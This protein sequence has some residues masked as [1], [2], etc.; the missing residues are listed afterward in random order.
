L[1]SLVD[2]GASAGQVAAGAAL[3]R[4]LWRALAAAL[5]GVAG[6]YVWVAVSAV[7]FPY[8]LDYAEGLV[9]Q[10]ALWLGSAKLYGDITKFPFLV[11][12]Y[13]PLFLAVLKGF[14]L[15]GLNV[16]A[17]GRAFSVACTL[18]ACIFS[19]GLT[20]RMTRAPFGHGPG[21]W[22]A[23]VAGLTPL[24]LLPLLSWSVLMRVD[25]LALCLTYAGLYCASV[26]FRRG[27]ALWAALPCF[28]AAAF[29]KQIY[30]A[31]AAAM[32]CICVIRAPRRT[33]AV[34]AVWGAAALACLFALEW[35]SEGR[36]LKH[37]LVY[38]AGAIDFA[39]AARQT[40]VWL[41]AYP[42]DVGL[43]MT[44]VIVAWRRGGTGAGWLKRV[45][46]DEA[47]AYLCFLTVY[48]ALTTL[49]LVAA[50]K[51][52][53]SRN[54]FIEWM[55][56]WCLWLG[57]LAAYVLSRPR[58]AGMLG[59]LMPVLLTLQLA[60]VLAGIR[61][62]QAQE[63]S[64]QRRADWGA[65]LARTQTI[66]GPLLSDD[67]VT[68]ILAGREVTLEPCVLMVLS[69]LGFYDEAKLIERLRGHYFAAVI[70]A[71]DPGDPTFD[72]RYL[73]RSRD[74]LLA[75]Y[76]HVEKYGDYRLRLP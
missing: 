15:A 17:T 43:V 56:C 5:L 28:V 29:T 18:V 67:M 33:L 49:M 54:Y 35:A 51:T 61:T 9:W 46:A 38:T 25:M 48:L 58:Q 52:G 20:Y 44:A 64:A 11:C 39:E 2:I 66:P 73:P 26:S 23:C 30:L 59:W 71:Y 16:L 21:V 63:F 36:F 31:G 57:W 47:F 12:E 45:R 32:F 75:A 68:T 1:D 10:E 3:R 7:R 53:A 76:P 55:C 69:R 27:G 42:V 14:S 72:S 13:P 24:T 70:T 50:G 8:G 37:I 19:G 34:Y 6:L 40:G 65:L 4:W 74:A 62:L 60:P 41:A 22:A